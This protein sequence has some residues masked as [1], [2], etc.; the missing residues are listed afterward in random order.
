MSIESPLAEAP[1]RAKAVS[2]AINRRSTLQATYIRLFRGGG[3]FLPTSRRMRLGDEI[4][5]NLRLMN[6]PDLIAT[7]G[8]VAWITPPGC[9]A[10]KT[11][12]VGV[13]FAADEA[14]RSARSKIEAILG[15]LTNAA[16][17]NHTL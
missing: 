2:L 16:Q 12:G 3:L 7:R 9:S 11:P 8:R 5:I 13:Q 6:D 17:P 14:G 1:R 10:R 4:V 15:G